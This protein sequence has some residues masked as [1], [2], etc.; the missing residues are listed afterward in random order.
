MITTN[1]DDIAVIAKAL[2]THGSGENGQRAYNLLNNIKEDV[3]TSEGHDDTVYNPL[4]YYNYLI[5]FNTRLDAIQAAIL[6]VKLPYLD[7]W[8]EKRNNNAMKY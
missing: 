2:R 8:V 6:S 7:E 3:K 5:G 1:N 4:K